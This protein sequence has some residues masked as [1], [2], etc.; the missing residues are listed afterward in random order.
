GSKRDWSSD[1]CSSDLGGG[2]GLVGASLGV[3][4]GVAGGSVA[5]VRSVVVGRCL[6]LLRGG[7]G[8]IVWCSGTELACIALIIGILFG[9]RPSLVS[10][11]VAAAATRLR[12]SGRLLA[13]LRRPGRRIGPARERAHMAL[14]SSAVVHGRIGPCPL[15]RQRRRCPC[16]RKKLS[17]SPRP[18]A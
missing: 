7:A 16:H 5:G 8:A 11:T 1:V 9:H 6:T 18:L 12:R 3:G 14:V 15:F 4:I 13:D 2:A 17:R 10:A